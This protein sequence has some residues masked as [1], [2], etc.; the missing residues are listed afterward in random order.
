MSLK[1]PLKKEISTDQKTSSHSNPNDDITPPGAICH[2][3]KTGHMYR[4]GKKTREKPERSASD[5]RPGSVKLRAVEN[6]RERR[7]KTWWVQRGQTHVHGYRSQKRWG[8]GV[9]R[10]IGFSEHSER[11]ADN[12]RTLSTAWVNY[13][14]PQ[15]FLWSPALTWKQ[16][17]SRWRGEGRNKRC[18]NPY[19]SSFRHR[20]TVTII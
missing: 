18:R 6:Y 7:A 1:N 13:K 10:S 12:E 15:F 20:Y 3:K 4:P 19:K 11:N 2:L 9:T 14:L 8:D 5:E 16:Q 17:F